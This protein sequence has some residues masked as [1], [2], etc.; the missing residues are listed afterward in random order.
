[1]KTAKDYLEAANAEVP[2]IPL[3]EAIVRHAKGGAVF[4]D[5]R[6][7]AAVAKT[8]SIAGAE[9]VPRGFLEFAADDATQYHNPAFQ[10]DAEI[11]LVCGAGGQAALA[12]K[13]LLEMGFAKVYNL[14]GFGDWKAGGGPTED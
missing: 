14:G 5:V 2:R 9:R 3:A 13:T 11:Y 4:V 1:M 12:G 10:K 6:D 8:G 7:S